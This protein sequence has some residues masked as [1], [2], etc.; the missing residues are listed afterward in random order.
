M[1]LMKIHADDK[2]RAK[3]SVFGRVNS[4]CPVS[5]TIM[6]FHRSIGDKSASYRRYRVGHHAGKSWNVDKL[7]EMVE[8]EQRTLSDISNAPSYGRDE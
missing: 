5:P 8:L 7:V 2:R 4:S 3:F 1:H 6:P